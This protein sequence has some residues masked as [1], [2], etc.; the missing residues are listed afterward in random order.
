MIKEFLSNIFHSLLR[1]IPY[2]NRLELDRIKLALVVERLENDLQ[3]ALVG[4]LGIS[5]LRFENNELRASFKTRMTKVF[6]EWA[7]L[8]F[9]DNPDCEN[10]IEIAFAH[11][12]D[13][14]AGT[15]R[16]QRYSG[17]S[18]HELRLEAEAER[19]AAIAGLAKAKQELE[20]WQN[21]PT[22]RKDALVLMMQ[23]ISTVL[24]I[25]WSCSDYDPED[26]EARIIARIANII[27]EKELLELSLC[28][29]GIEYEDT[30]VPRGRRS[31]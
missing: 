29:G 3:K 19:D 10:Y 7:Y 8:M 27:S 22:D 12:S 13:P 11:E 1:L 6:A 24:G 9:Q 4:D 15:I 17:K 25:G 30:D 21:M 5:S 28:N 16:I 26:Y 18:P 23:R 31:D 20:D 14:F 2:V